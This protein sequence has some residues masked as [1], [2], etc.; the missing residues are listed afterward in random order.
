MRRHNTNAAT[1]SAPMRS[2][3]V[4][5]ITIAFVLAFAAML[6]LGGLLLIQPSMILVMPSGL[7][8]LLKEN[9][10]NRVDAITGWVFYAAFV[11]CLLLSRRRTWFILLYSILCIA[12]VLN[13]VGCYKVVNSSL[14]DIK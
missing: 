3:K 13:V 14:H 4:R 11:I 6:P 8:A 1:A 5:L 2:T 7:W 9:D 12:L 10:P